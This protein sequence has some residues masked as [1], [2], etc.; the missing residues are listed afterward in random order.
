M[1]LNMGER[2]FL[3]KIKFSVLTL[4]LL[5]SCGGPSNATSISLNNNVSTIVVGETHNLV[6]KVNPTNYVNVLSVTS[7]NGTV[8]VNSIG[9]GAFS[10]TGVSAGNSVITAATDNGVSATMNMTV[11]TQ[12]QKFINHLITEDYSVIT[13]MTQDEDTTISYG[14]A[15]DL[16]E[17]EFYFSVLAVTGDATSEL[18]AYASYRF[19][20]GQLRS[21]EGRNLILYE[22]GS[23]SYSAFYS[24]GSITFSSASQMRIGTYTRLLNSFPSTFSLVDL[25][26]LSADLLVLSYAALYDYCIDNNLGTS[27]F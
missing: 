16:E 27:Y 4:L 10:V 26:N 11:I 2:M 24:F 1:L 6:V 8:R 9:D 7:S 23:T 19:T 15:Y 18:T 3:N 20:W 25:V 13:R 22:R 21:G 12:Q 14:F 5:A 17:R